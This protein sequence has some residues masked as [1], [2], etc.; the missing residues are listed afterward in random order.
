MGDLH[1]MIAA[2]CDK[3]KGE[4]DPVTVGGEFDASTRKYVIKMPVEC[5]SNFNQIFEILDDPNN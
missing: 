1:Q 2:F 5:Y 3:D 4:I